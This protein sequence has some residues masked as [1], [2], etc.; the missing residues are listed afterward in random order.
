MVTK[1]KSQNLK[2]I[3][4]EI[5]LFIDSL[6]TETATSFLTPSFNKNICICKSSPLMKFIKNLFEKFQCIQRVHFYKIC[7]M[8]RN[9]ADVCV[10]A[11]LAVDIRLSSMYQKRDEYVFKASWTRL[12][13]VL[14]TSWK[15]LKDVLNSSLLHIIKTSW[16]DV[17]MATSRFE[18]A[19]LKSFENVF[20]R[21]RQK[22]SSSVFKT[23][24]PRRLFAGNG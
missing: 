19:F 12:E 16:Q 3:F 20:R 5:L 22:T 21:Q 2:N 7:T 15:C 9:S 23:S 6:F 14:R 4:L 17:L 1:V 11:N 18:K 8:I 24:I 10:E 13:D